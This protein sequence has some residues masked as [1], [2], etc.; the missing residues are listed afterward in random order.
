[1]K[2]NTE[3]CPHCN[4]IRVVVRKIDLSR[5]CNFCGKQVA[6]APPRTPRKKGQMLL[7]GGG[8]G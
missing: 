5:W 1:M 6:V 4:K 3:H 7:P 8:N 2:L